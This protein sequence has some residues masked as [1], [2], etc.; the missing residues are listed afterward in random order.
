MRIERIHNGIVMDHITAGM[1]MEILKLFPPEL[2]ETKIDY[3][4]YV[5]SN[6]L[7]KKDIIK[8]EN[9]DVA[10]KTL[11]KMTLLSPDTT[12]STIREGQVAEKEEPTVPPEVE[13]VLT[14]T[15]PKCITLKEPYLV[16]RFRVK[17]EEGNFKQQCQYCE[18]I[19]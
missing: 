15:N 7:G 11:M 3:A 17:W 13:G 1:G 4:S 5:D 19:S 10:P 8:I 2:L 6:R 14:C 9:L 18:H 16:S 12:I